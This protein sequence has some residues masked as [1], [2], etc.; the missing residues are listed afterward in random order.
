MNKSGWRI[1]CDTSCSSMNPGRDPENVP[2]VTRTGT[3]H[4]ARILVF[5]SYAIPFVI[6]LIL[7]GVCLGYTVATHRQI[8]YLR[9]PPTGVRL[10]KCEFPFEFELKD[11]EEEHYQIHPFFH[12][13][14]GIAAN[15]RLPSSTLATMHPCLQYYHKKLLEAGRVHHQLASENLLEGRQ[16]SFLSRV[17]A[18]AHTA[19]T[20][21]TCRPS[22]A[23]VGKTL[24]EIGAEAVTEDTGAALAV[25][26]VESLGAMCGM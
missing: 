12:D 17:K 7:G 11:V 2:L 4:S 23:S 5:W 21:A 1:R 18:V 24:V 10:T 15:G 8:L 6:G 22:V 14:S 20:L 26:A 25:T 13:G 9:K 19:E 16:L 3:H